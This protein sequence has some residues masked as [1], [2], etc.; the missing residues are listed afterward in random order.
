MKLEKILF[1]LSILGILLLILIF[2]I[3]APTYKG[4]I[5]SIQSSNNKITV[6]LENSSTRLILFDTTSINLSKG[7][8]IEFQGKQDT[9]NE[10]EQI[11]VDKILKI[12]N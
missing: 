11:I 2:Q 3:T 6:Q 10:Q 5:K 12:K 7:D 9:Y 8:I 1:I 4:T